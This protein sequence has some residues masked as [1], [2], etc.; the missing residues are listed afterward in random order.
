MGTRTV[1]QIEKGVQR[2][3]ETANHLQNLSGMSLD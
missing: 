2:H 1:V 3:I